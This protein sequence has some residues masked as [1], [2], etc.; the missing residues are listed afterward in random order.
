MPQAV[1]GLAG[2]HRR[3]EHRARGRG[4]PTSSGSGARSRSTRSYPSSRTEDPRLP[5][6][7]ALDAGPDRRGGRGLAPARRRDGRRR[8][9]ELATRASVQRDAHLVKYT[10]ACL[11][12]AADRPHPRT[13]LPGCG[14]APQRLVGRGH[15][16]AASDITLASGTAGEQRGDR[17]EA[18]SS[19]SAR[20]FEPT[21]NTRLP[22]PLRHQEPPM[23]IDERALEQLIEQSDDVQ[24]DA[25]RATREPLAE[26]TEHGLE[27]RAHGGEDLDETRQFQSRRNQLLRRPARSR[28]ACSPR[29]ASVP[30]SSRSAPPRPGRTRAATCRCCRPQ[31]RSRTSRSRPTAPPSRSRS[32]VALGERRGQGLRDEDQ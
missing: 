23:S 22:P 19:A 9:G 28:A 17:P 26:L 6:A 31:R 5:L 13:P 18:T 32:S 2:R 25:M 12:A 3:P 27:Q 24:A 21:G 8:H 11:D 30:R 29:P 20:G 1:L 4:A 14:R 10:L 15:E 7:D 16:R